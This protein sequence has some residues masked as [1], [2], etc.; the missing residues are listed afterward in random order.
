MQG[1][2]VSP[3]VL[4][5]PG[6]NMFAKP[7][8]LVQVLCLIEVTL[9]AAVKVVELT[10]LPQPSRNCGAG[11]TAEP[12]GWTQTS[13]KSEPTTPRIALP[14]NAFLPTSKTVRSAPV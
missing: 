7:R 2:L 5:V 11:P 4:A 9:S 14:A 12:A 3:L 6:T 13:R 10:L 1:V 8:V